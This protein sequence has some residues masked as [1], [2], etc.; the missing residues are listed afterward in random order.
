MGWFDEQI[1]QRKTVDDEVFGDSFLKMASSVLGR[2]A[3]IRSGEHAV[4]E[5]SV[6]EILKYFHCG[7]RQNKIPD[8]RKL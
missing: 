8:S 5:E 1:R 6:S 3:A 7:G 4:T 2:H